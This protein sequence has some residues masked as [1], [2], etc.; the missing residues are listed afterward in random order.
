MLEGICHL[1]ETED[2]WPGEDFEEPTL[3]PLSKHKIFDPCKKCIVRACCTKS[4]D[5]D[6]K[7]KYDYTKL[8]V[9]TKVYSFFKLLEG[10]S[11]GM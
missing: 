6:P 3:F 10:L 5:C 1:E 11:H 9:D 2:C 4:R 7:I 8:Y